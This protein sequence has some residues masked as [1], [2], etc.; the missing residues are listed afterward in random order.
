MLPLNWFSRDSENNEYTLFDVDLS[1][2]HFDDLEGVYIIWRVYYG[3]M[4]KAVYV[5][6]GIIKNRLRAHRNN[7][8]ILQYQSEKKPLY[9]AW[10]E[11]P[12][13]YKIGVEM[14]LHNELTP[15]VGIPPQ[16][17]PTPVR[18]NLPS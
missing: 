10:A 13:D 5:G 15:L 18:V 14:Y 6:Q 9:V 12:W 11:V 16:G 2:P 17:N 8:D 3:I 7:P 1:H 4:P